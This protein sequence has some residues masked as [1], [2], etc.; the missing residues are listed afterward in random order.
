MARRSPAEVSGQHARPMGDLL[1][2]MQEERGKVKEL[3]RKLSEKNE[4]VSA[5]SVLNVYLFSSVC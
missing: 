4:A 3:M 2:Q 5:V 1:I